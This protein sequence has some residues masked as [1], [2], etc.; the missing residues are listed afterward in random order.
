MTAPFP[1]HD[2]YVHMQLSCDIWV[3]PCSQIAT[4][5]SDLRHAKDEVDAK[6]HNANKNQVKFTVTLPVQGTEV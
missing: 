5:Y 6:I 3:S 2:P 1:L 4:G